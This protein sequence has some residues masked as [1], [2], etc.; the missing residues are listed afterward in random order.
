[1]KFTI[2]NKFFYFFRSK[3][4]IHIRFF[5]EIYFSKFRYKHVSQNRPPLN[6]LELDREFFSKFSRKMT[7]VIGRFFPY[8]KDFFLHKFKS[9]K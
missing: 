8:E 5:N 2:Q 9:E 7:L 3:S 4:I 1:M 6:P